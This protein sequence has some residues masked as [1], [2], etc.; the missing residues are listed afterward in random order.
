MVAISG[1]IKK[2]WGKKD[3]NETP[4]L[5]AVIEFHNNSDRKNPEFAL[6]AFGEY[7]VNQLDAANEGDQVIVMGF[8]N[9]YS[10]KREDE[11]VTKV[12]IGIN[13]VE[14]LGKNAVRNSDDDAFDAAKPVN[15]DE[16][17]PV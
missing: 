13:K 9:Q 1:T 3:L 12:D 14:V 16:E 7:A 5:G 4:T 6:N 8:L 15:V 10:F 2:K 11:W 17:C